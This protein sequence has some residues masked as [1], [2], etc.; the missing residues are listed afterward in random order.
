SH[1][2]NVG[3]DDLSVVGFNFIESSI[4]LSFAPGV[5]SF[6]Y[7]STGQGLGP[8]MRQTCVSVGAACAVARSTKAAAE[9]PASVSAVRAEKTTLE[10]PGVT[11]SYAKNPHC[12]CVPAGHFAS[13]TCLDVAGS[14]APGQPRSTS[15][16]A[17]ESA[18]TVWQ[19]FG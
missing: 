4:K 15:I 7:K 1:D 3:A 2:F 17:P 9:R 14:Y 5:L 11:L 16:C 8:L 6:E 12:T 19:V 13:Y 18:R 10:L